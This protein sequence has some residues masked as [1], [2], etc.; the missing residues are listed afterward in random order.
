[1]K[2][3]LFCGLAGLLAWCSPVLSA[4]YL[5]Q[6]QEVSNG[7]V[8]F[9]DGHME[10]QTFTAGLS[11]MLDHIEFNAHGDYPARV[12]IRNTV[13]GRPGDFVLGSVFL[14]D[15]FD[16]L[17]WDSID[18]S[19]Q[20]IAI[21]SGVM[22]AIVFSNT[23]PSDTFWLSDGVATARLPAPYSGGDLWE[24]WEG[25]WVLD[26]ADMPADIQFR[27]YVNTSPTMLTVSSTFGGCVAEP[28]EG[29]FSFDE[30]ALVSVVAQADSGY[31]FLR[32]TGTA[33]SAGK[34]ANPTSSATTVTMAGYYTLIAEFETIQH[35][36]TLSS[37][38]DGYV[39]SPGEGAFSY[40]EGA[41][42]PVVAQANNGCR[43]VCWTGTA[44]N[45]RQVADP[46]ARSTTVT[47]AADYTLVAEFR[48]IGSVWCFLTVTSTAGGHVSA[49]GEGSFTYDSGSEILITARADAGYRFSGWTGT[50][51]DA[52]RVVDPAA[53]NTAVAMD[54][55]YDLCANFAADG[56]SS[57]QVLAPNG[58]E[59]LTAGSIGSI[60]W[61]VQ[62]PI[63]YI[64][65]ELSVDG[66][67]TWTQVFQQSGPSG[68]C[69]WA[70]PSVNS[71]SCLIRIRAT[72][73]P[74]ISDTSDAPFSIHTAA[75]RVWYVDAAATGSSSGQ[76]W[77]NAFVCLQD[78]LAQAGTGDD[79]WVAQGR[80]WPDL[81]GGQ[82]AGDRAATF[83][84]ENGVAIHGGFPSGGG[85]WLQRNPVLYP[86]ILS[87]DIGTSN[88]A[89]DNSYHVV[90]GH[91]TN[92]TAILDGCTIC[93][94]YA[95]G[96][97]P[98]DRGAGL[99]SP[100]GSPQ[101]RNCLFVGNTAPGGNGGG[102]CNIESKA[103]FI[104]CVFSG[105]TA[106]NCGGG[107]Y[108][109]QGAVTVLNCTFV[110]N[111]GLW[112]GGGVFNAAGTLAVTNCILWGNGRMNGNSY[113]ELAQ[114][115]G[116]PKPSLR[117]CCVQ[118]W[119]G[120]LGGANNFGRDP[121]FV[122]TNGPDGV[123]GTPDDDLRLQPDSPC[124]DA[125]DNAAVPLSVMTDLQGKARIANG[126][127][128]LGAYEFSEEN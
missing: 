86:S 85:D 83:Q 106:G 2:A 104:N 80:Y 28:G 3:C 127:V 102:A 49:P 30:G 126:V 112:R 59:S 105:N 95:N 32:W 125:G 11:G 37:T 58:G 7:Q 89:T 19:S 117:Y 116:D 62:G 13:G 128:D 98:Q 115:S 94:G 77:A 1:M 23:E 42:V 57:V 67:S 48:V 40:D 124:I 33:V 93:D 123:A 68:S 61:Q 14:P 87:G 75:Q 54:A 101:V 9:Y 10:A 97:E 53:A 111:Q 45:A 22:Y 108:S 25:V 60:R 52:G 76:N 91:G 12:Q 8:K 5:D 47:M 43:F 6:H 107:L 4:V 35:T 38:V 119:T 27:T 15:G 81:G 90:S 70:V 120:S 51:V 99:Y 103:T 109:E 79:I 74:G 114:V 92:D 34:V 41:V 121:L 29:A 20:N 56:P 78:A 65:V 44:V 24:T 31:R 17:H 84:L 63:A 69:D 82:T 72:Q 96:A 55:D 50:A 18:F 71:D 39:A 26:D 66:G 113:D 100:R 88:V 46:T 64:A 118:G 122:N 21:T 73:N 16:N 110:A 36:L